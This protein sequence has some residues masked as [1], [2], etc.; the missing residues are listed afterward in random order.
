M[1]WRRWAGL[2][3]TAVKTAETWYIQRRLVKALEDDMVCY[4][5][6]VRNSLGDFIL[7][8][9]ARMAWT[10]LTSKK[11]TIEMFGPNDSRV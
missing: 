11:K 2:I 7:D 4:D 6:T 10:A 9:F 3:K 8:L 5:G 1:L